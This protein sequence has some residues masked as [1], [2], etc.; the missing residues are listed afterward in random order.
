MLAFVDT[1]AALIIFQSVSHFA[2]AD[3]VFAGEENSLAIAVEVA[4]Q[5]GH[6]CVADSVIAVV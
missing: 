3:A 2:D 4:E 5:S 1:D 6:P